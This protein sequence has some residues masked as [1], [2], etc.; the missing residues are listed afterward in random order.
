MSEF[1]DTCEEQNLTIEQLFRL[2]I[3]CNDN[4]NK[5]LNVCDSGLNPAD[6]L[7]VDC[8][9]L[10]ISSLSKRVIGEDDSGNPCIQF[11]RS[12]NEDLNIT[13]VVDYLGN[14]VVDYLGNYVTI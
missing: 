2:L 14:Y 10:P 12:D 7:P 6:L 11:V 5:Y 3:Y 1:I 4:G 8:Y 13:H 9:Y